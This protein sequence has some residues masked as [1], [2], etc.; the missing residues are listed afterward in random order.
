VSFTETVI[1]L[2]SNLGSQPDVQA[3]PL[4]LALGGAPVQNE[5]AVQERY[6][7]RI[8]DAV[9]G[10]LRPELLN[11]IQQLVFFDPLSAAAVQQIID[12][13]LDNRGY[14]CGSAGSTL[15]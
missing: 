3:Q 14:D 1:I 10:A 5:E 4:G 13:I 2:T 8:I 7:R 12:K 11:R 15:S 6:H 9:R